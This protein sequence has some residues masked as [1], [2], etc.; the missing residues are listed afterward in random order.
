MIILPAPAASGI[1]QVDDT[2][3]IEPVVIDDGGG[4]VAEPLERSREDVTSGT[5]GSGSGSSSPF[6]RWVT[7]RVV[8]F[9]VA[10]SLVLGGAVASVAWYARSAYFVTI[11]H[12]HIAILQGRPGGVLW[13]QP[14]LTDLTI[15]S[16]SSVLPYDLQSLRSGQLEPSLGQAN[17]YVKNLVA[18]KEEAE[19]ADQPPPRGA[20]TTTK[21]S[22]TTTK[23]SPTTTKSSP[24]TTGSSGRAGA[25]SPATAHGGATTSGVPRSHTPTTTA[26]SSTGPSSTGTSGTGTSGTGTS[27]TGA[28]K[29][30]AVTS[31]PGSG[32]PTAAP[33]VAPTVK[34]TVAP[35]VTSQAPTTARP[36]TTRPSH[37]G[38]SG[39]TGRPTPVSG[40]TRVVPPTA[41]KTSAGP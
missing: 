38:R 36:T 27:G 7:L 18:A 23:S 2:A 11:M 26:P 4:P 19:L 8:G 20:P 39:T 32:A 29:R 25:T 31:T 30:K 41:A 6:P 13:F 33:T 37:T 14:T 24:T 17:Q 9:V 1:E 3:T 5:S 10:L 15:Y 22:P 35:T 28:A 34:P 16:S 21:T 40:T 12:G